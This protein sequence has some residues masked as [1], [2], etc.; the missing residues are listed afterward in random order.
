MV[1]KK[2]IIDGEVVPVSKTKVKFLGQGSFSG[3]SPQWLKWLFR[4]VVI[5]TTAAAVWV[6]GTSL[7][8]ASMKNEIML[9]FKFLDLITLGI[10]NG[11]GRVKK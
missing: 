7:I 2:V 4:G 5:F 10:T 3:P 8:D 9:G 11:S 6:N 1:E